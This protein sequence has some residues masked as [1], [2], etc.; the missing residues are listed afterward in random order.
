MANLVRPSMALL[1]PPN[2]RGG[3]ERWMYEYVHSEIACYLHDIVPF[4]TFGSVAQKE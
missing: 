2:P 4:G 1:A 3:M